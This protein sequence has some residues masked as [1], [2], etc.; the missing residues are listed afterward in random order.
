MTNYKV[1][2]M[3]YRTNFEIDIELEAS[4]KKLTRQI[5]D[6]AAIN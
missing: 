2:P 6:R 5:V 1:K 4:E 3:I